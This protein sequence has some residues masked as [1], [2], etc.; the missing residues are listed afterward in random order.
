M[1]TI[2]YSCYFDNGVFTGNSTEN[3]ATFNV[4]YLGPMGLLGYL[5]RMLGLT[6]NYPDATDRATRYAAAL[7]KHLPEDPGA[8]YAKAFETDEMGVAKDLI[9]WRD[10]LVLL[11]WKTLAAEGQPARLKTLAGVEKQF[12][13]RWFHYGIA[14]RWQDVLHALPTGEGLPGCNLLVYDDPS[15]VHPFFK[16]LFARPGKCITFVDPNENIT[17]D[18]NNLGLVKSLLLGK[19]PG[20]NRFRSIGDDNSFSILHLKDNHFAADLL[21]NQV[22][23]GFNPV[24]INGENK[25][26]DHYLEANGLP[27][28]GS[29]L[30]NSNPLIIQLFKLAAVGLISPLNVYNLLS[31]LQS[32]YSPI[33][34]KLSASLARQLIEK[35]GIG[36][37]QWQESID[38][39]FM[40]RLTGN[41]QEEQ[42]WNKKRE[43]VEH[44]LTFNFGP[45]V[46][47][48]RIKKTY[49]LL[50]AWADKHALPGIYDHSDGERDQ[51]ACLSR[52]AGALLKKIHDSVDAISV[53]EF[54]RL[55][56][57]IYEPATFQNELIQANSVQHTGSPGELLGNP[58]VVWW[59]DCYNTV[60][61]ADIHAFLYAGEVD[62]LTRNGI[63]IYLPASQVK[64][65]YEKAKRGILAARNQCVLVVV[66]K[67]NG[68]EV[69]LHPVMS[70]INAFFQNITGISTT[71]GDVEK[72]TH[73]PPQELFSREI[74]LPQPKTRWEISNPGK[75][76][77]RET[78]SASSIEKLIQHPFEWV[79]RYQARLNSGNSFT[80]PELFT[81]K[82]SIAHATTEAILTL[83]KNGPGFK[84]NDTLIADHL[85][86][87]IREEGLVFMLPEMRFEYEELVR[88]YTLAIKS[89][90]SIIV[91]NELTVVDC[92]YYA[93]KNIPRIGEVAG[94]MDLVMENKSGRQVI[95]DLKWTRNNKKYQSRLAEGK[96]VQ[97]AVYYRLLGTGPMTAYFMFDSG[98]L[99]TGH[100]LS[101]AG[102]VPVDVPADLTEQEVLAKTC[103]SLAF[104]WEE[105]SRGDIEIGD[106]AGV[107]DLPYYNATG[108]NLLIPL[109]MDQSKKIKYA[110]AYSGLELF[111][112]NIH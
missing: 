46:G 14:D 57:S 108:E 79:I 68:E 85:N 33:P 26:L 32:P 22:K 34:K 41:E 75:L 61:R 8:F 89:L 2:H 101:G 65:A 54:L 42:R 91:K 74:T 38:L 51:F 7:R 3:N 53:A 17:M 78:E 47:I 12:A 60:I 98:K 106:N 81:L 50:K 99:Y 104:R 16:K 31:L 21:A 20:G 37:P 59:L 4:A 72:L 13:D 94:K 102:V 45:D 64:M 27:A 36:N 62:F 80:L 25:I 86:R 77:K 109:E 71:F 83:L 11:G 63:E 82:G 88:K 87:K 105:L 76:S 95:F 28:S 67:H 30:T 112:G 35:P 52:M 9:R 49:S 40:E 66:E 15:L 43:E 97:L 44:L 90:V 10:D 48:S 70:E 18:H 92:E 39:Y 107:A 103:N 96:S 24:V 56:E 73:I 93:R 110:D 29:M 84:L 23:Q 111:K 55:T 19:K 69:S 100:N 6:G 58:P 1:L 5:E